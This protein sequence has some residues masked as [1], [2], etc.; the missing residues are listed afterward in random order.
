MSDADLSGPSPTH[1][2]RMRCCLCGVQEEADGTVELSDRLQ[3]VPTGAPASAAVSVRFAEVLKVRLRPVARS[4]TIATSASESVTF[5]TADD[6][7]RTLGAKLASML[8]EVNVETDDGAVTVP[9]QG[10]VVR[11]ELNS[12][13]TVA[14]HFYVDATRVWFEPGLDARFLWCR[15]FEAPIHEVRAVRRVSGGRRVCVTIGDREVVLRGRS[16][17]RIW[18]ALCALRDATLSVRSADLLFFEDAG[19]GGTGGLFAVGV[20]G[21]GYGSSSDTFGLAQ[22]F[23]ESVRELRY[24]RPDGHMVVIGCRTRSHTLEGG[25]NGSVSSALRDRWLESC[26]EPHAQDDRFGVD[27]IMSRDGDMR[28]GTLGVDQR[29]VVYTPLDGEAVVLAARSALV[30]ASVEEGSANV[31]RIAVNEELHRVYVPHAAECAALLEGIFYYPSWT[32]PDDYTDEHPLSEGEYAEMVGA[33]VYTNLLYRGDVVANASGPVLDPQGSRVKISMIA[34][35]ME[36]PPPFA[37]TLEVGNKRGRFMINTLVTAVQVGSVRSRGGVNVSPPLGIS[38]KFTGRVRQR[39]RREFFRLPLRERLLSLRFVAGGTSQTTA[40]DIRLTD[41]SRTGCGLLL[42]VSPDLGSPCAF[43][44]LTE[45]DI[46]VLLRARVVGVS[47]G[48]DKKYRVGVSFDPGSAKSAIALFGERERSALK[49]RR[50]GEDGEG[51]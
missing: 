15:P 46:V 45:G 41:L 23:W 6:G 12:L 9:R 32:L 30:H 8:P 44:V 27:A 17:Q 37:A 34:A 18:V 29:G 19:S 21:F 24:L 16:A 10:G 43:E 49:K 40:I 36:C 14:G 47:P 51:E 35:G 7:Y 39:N 26:A 48:V 3:F 42:A 1:E 22:S 25:R 11:F 20:S 4:I 50:E 33:A 5:R 38:L 28:F 2:L 13:L 31:L